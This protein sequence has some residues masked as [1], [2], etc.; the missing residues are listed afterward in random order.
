MEIVGVA[1]VLRVLLVRL[2][3]C[4]S[5][6][7][8]SGLLFFVDSDSSVVFSFVLCFYTSSDVKSFEIVLSFAGLTNGFFLSF[9][10][11]EARLTDV[12]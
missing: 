4:S 2:V 10:I 6:V 3:R 1:S 11:Q 8:D 5:E 7:V 9:F 12:L